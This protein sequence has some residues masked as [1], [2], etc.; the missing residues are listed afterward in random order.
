VL[1]IVLAL[2]LAV[3]LIKLGVGLASGALAVVADAFHSLVDSSSNVIALLGVWVAARPADEN[4]PYGHHK[5]ETIAALGIG[6]LLL[7]AAFEIGKSVVARLL[8]GS[9]APAVTLTTVGLMALTFVVNLSIVAYETRAGRRLNSEVLLADAAHTRTDLF[10]TLSVIASLVGTRFGLAWLDPLVAAVVVALLFRAAF[11]ILRSTSD[12]LTDVAV[13]NPDEV[14]RIALEVPGV[15]A[16]GDVRSRGRADAA[17]VDLHVQVHPAMDADQAHGVAS[18]VERRLT[19]AVPGIV[20]AVVHVE[21]GRGAVSPWEEL[22]VVLRGLADG[23]GIGLHDLHAHVERDG[24]YAIETHLEVEAGLTLGAAHRLADQFERRVREALP[25]V[26]SVVTHIEPL[27]AALPD[28][29]GRI[30]RLPD[31]RRRIIELADGVAG[32]GACHSL[33]L[34]NVDGHLTATLHVTQP[35][36]TPLT[37]AHALAETIERKLHADERRLHRVVVHVEP[38]E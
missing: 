5:Y 8:G 16:A 36:D 33:R 14:R 9:P 3:T 35:A 23:M 24:T 17:Y 29:A 10:V 1:W 6:G 30:S 38:P 15:R 27:P 21:P 2:N 4:H 7:V 18:E 13:A 11:K 31:L 20:D 32:R 34:H 22:A 12:V 26:R 19:Q 37:Q 28:E 25:E